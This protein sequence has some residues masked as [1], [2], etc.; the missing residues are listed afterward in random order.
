MFIVINITNNNNI[1]V[2]SCP[3]SNP[4]IENSIC[5]SRCASGAYSD[6]KCLQFCEDHYI[7]NTTNL[8]SKQCY[9]F[10]PASHNFLDG[11]QCVQSCKFFED[12]IIPNFF[13]C[14]SS[15]DLYELVGSNQH[16]LKQ[17]GK[18]QTNKNKQCVQKSSNK[19]V[20]GIAVPLVLLLVFGAVFAFI[21]MKKKKKTATKENNT[22]RQ[23][24]LQTSIIP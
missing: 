9:T 15:C 12:S 1:C 23:N 22:L 20:V 21:F 18:N 3:G 2:N 8:D 11:K 5:V 19:T 7:V 14:V 16:C 17:C 13:T 6:F 10:C 4:Y 24:G